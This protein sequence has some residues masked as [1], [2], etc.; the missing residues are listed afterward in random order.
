LHDEVTD[1]RYQFQQQLGQLKGGQGAGP[2]LP[3]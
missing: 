1:I 2:P 3:Y